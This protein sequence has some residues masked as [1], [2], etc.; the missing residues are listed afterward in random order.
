[1]YSVMPHMLLLGKS[2][3]AWV[4]SPDGKEK[5]LIFVDNWDFNWQMAF[6]LKEPMHVPAG[7]KIH[8][9]GY[10]DNSKSNPNNPSNPPKTVTFGE[11]TTDEMFLLVAAYTV[12]R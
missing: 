2:M 5:P 3:K 6:M 11:Q 1:L 8:V 7:S 10:Y 12:D 9:E 4:E